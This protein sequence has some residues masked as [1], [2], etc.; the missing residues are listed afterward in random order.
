MV[1]QTE[2]EEMIADQ[3]DFEPIEDVSELLEDFE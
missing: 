3:S 2:S 1:T